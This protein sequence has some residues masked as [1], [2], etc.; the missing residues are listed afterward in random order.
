MDAQGSLQI[1]AGIARTGG[2][3][4]AGAALSWRTRTNV[5]GSADHGGAVDRKFE[6]HDAATNPR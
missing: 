6:H 5:R 2:R 3:R 1:M 4:A